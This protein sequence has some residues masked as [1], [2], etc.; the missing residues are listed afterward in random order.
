ML[1]YGSPVPSSEHQFP[2]TVY[3][4][5]WLATHANGVAAAEKR[6]GPDVWASLSINKADVEARWPQDGQV[7]VVQ[8]VLP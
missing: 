1:W 5:A 4:S 8:P 7:L 3:S 6:Y 2:S